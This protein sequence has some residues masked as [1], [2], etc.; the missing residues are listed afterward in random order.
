MRIS[1]SLSKKFANTSF[2][3]L[4]LMALIIALTSFAVHVVPYLRQLTQTI[5]LFFNPGEPEVNMVM[6]SLDL[7]GEMNPPTWFKMVPLLLCSLLLAAIAYIIKRNGGRYAL[8]WGAMSVVFAVMS[9]DEVGTLHEHYI[10]NLR[11]RWP[12]NI[13]LR[14]A[15]VYP[16]AVVVLLFVLASLRVLFDL[17]WEYRL[18][19][20]ASGFLYV[21][22]ALGL[23]MLSEAQVEHFDQLNVP[24]QDRD[25]NI[26]YI[27]LQSFK[28]FLKLS[29]S[30]LFLYSLM[31]YTIHLDEHQ[32][33]AATQTTSPDSSRERHDSARVST[34]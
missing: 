17:P 18:L 5:S 24:L 10:W 13:L 30:F 31:R 26:P 27:A 11:G 3:I 1:I 25:S 7:A 33:P 32:I 6:Q 22:G 8:Q 2:L 19:F 28:D 15:W 14:Y 4:M 23:E 29:G 34:P 12:D 16:L 21:L 9:M 20:I